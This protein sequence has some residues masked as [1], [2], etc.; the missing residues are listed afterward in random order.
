MRAEDDALVAELV[1]KKGWLD[2]ARIRRAIE[3]SDAAR[4]LNLEQGLLH[5]LVQKG[6]LGDQQARELTG[7]LSL[8]HLCRPENSRAIAGYLVHGQLEAWGLGAVLDARQL[9]MDRPVALKVMAPAVARDVGLLERFL[10]EGRT[11]GQVSHPNVVGAIDLGRCG[12]YCYYATEKLE[13]QSLRALLRGGPLPVALALDLARQTA[14]ALA[15]LHDLSLTHRDVQPDNIVLAPNGL[16]RLRNVGATRLPGDPSVQRTGIPIGTPGYSAPELAAN[17][18]KADIRADLYSLGA[19]LYH[20]VTGQRPGDP[21]SGAVP[22]PSALRPDLPSPVNDLIWR[23]MALD[24]S[25]RFP[26][27][28]ALLGAL[29]EAQAG[30]RAAASL[31][32]AVAETEQEPPGPGA[33][34]PEI[35]PLIPLPTPPSPALE[36]AALPSIGPPEQITPS[37]PA[38]ARRRR[39]AQVAWA[40]AFAGLAIALAVATVWAVRTRLGGLARAPRPPRTEEAPNGKATPAEPPKEPP[41]P[42]PPTP[43]TRPEPEAPSGLVRI[44][45]DALAFDR[46]NPENHAEAL[47]RLRRG[48]LAVGDSP[49]ALKLQA[50]LLARQQGLSGQANGAYTEL[51]NRL[52]ALRAEGRFGAALQACSV[53]PESLRAGA[54][55]DLVAARFAELLEEGERHY[56][57]LAARGAR[58][59]QDERPD[60]ALNAYKAIA[61]IGIPWISRAGGALATAASVY[62]EE[63]KQRLAEAAARRAVLDRRRALGGLAKHFAAVYE[64]I[65]KRDYAKALEVCQAV[66]DSLREGERGK[67]L[68]AL[69]RRLA[70]VA[71]LWEA[72]LKGPPS[73]I[74]QAF[75]LHGNEWV[76]DG[77]AGSGLNAQVVLRSTDARER[78]LRQLI[79]RL[80][81]QQLARLAECAVAREPAAAADLKVGLLCLVEGEAARARQK[82]LE[83]EK[84]GQDVAAHLDELEAETLV[85]GALAAHR[86]GQW[87]EA[88]KLLE[89]ALDRFGTSAATIL[90]HRVLSNAL[91]DCLARLG[92]PKEPAS[93]AASELP[94]ALQWLLVLPETRLGPLP[95]PNP[96]DAVSATPLQRRSPVRLGLDGW[97]DVTLSLRWTAAEPASPVVL[98]ARV[99]EPQPGQ[100]QYYYVAVGDGQVALGRSDAAGAKVLASKPLPAASGA[101]ARRLTFSLVG[102]SLSVTLDDGTSLTAADAALANGRLALAAPGAWVLVHE[103]LARPSAPRRPAAKER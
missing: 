73:A 2:S 46:A 76:I 24:P 57:T 97:S 54:W 95:P 65:K 84:A 69:E 13:G 25:K 53:F 38:G 28:A 86:Q 83:A 14:Q 79:W 42:P 55:G 12:D 68:A 56:L 64:E 61:D 71:G 32:A 52:A 10:L 85:A 35:A 88:R 92:E 45:E 81:G 99:A 6:F 23:L 66:P 90:S 19:T 89:T 18:A 75:S 41:S 27:P 78:T 60:D 9:S 29:E 5:V 58:A 80:P 3:L 94:D 51:A 20:V 22:P 40:S 63:Q 49:L 62:A 34:P 39:L 59:F 21:T 1:L 70:I 74:G 102:A 26:D 8:E 101:G 4:A 77:F 16:V 30:I 103:L 43:R 82:L 91:G 48:L 31:A 11:A 87:A 67:A 15:H 100:F 36:P 96:L 72:I 7:E 93:A 47:L 33:P 50:R 37:A 44:A 17:G 98:A